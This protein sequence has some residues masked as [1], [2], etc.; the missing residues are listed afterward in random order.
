MKTCRSCQIQKS[1]E[2]FYK[3]RGSCKICVGER[4]AIYNVVHAKQQ[5]I[6]KH[7]YYKAHQAR[8]AKLNREWCLRNPTKNQEYKAKERIKLRQEMLNAYGRKCVCCGEIYEAFL[9]LDHIGGGGKAHRAT[10]GNGLVYRDLRKR[11]WPK[12]GFQI[13]CMNCNWAIRFGGICPHKEN[14]DA[15]AE[16]AEETG[17]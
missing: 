4:V 5:A 15:K 8:A 13:L 12:E 11:G 10:V 9:T 16:V 17:C 7:A 6:R 14:A 3:N 2:E 1:V